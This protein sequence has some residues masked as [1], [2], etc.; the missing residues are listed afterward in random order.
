MCPETIFGTFLIHFWSIEGVVSRGRAPG[1]FLDHLGGCPVPLQ[2]S[3]P[4]RHRARPSFR[5][6]PLGHVVAAPHAKW[7]TVHLG[8]HLHQQPFGEPKL[9]N[10]TPS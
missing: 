7:S 8:S 6:L 9:G 5:V 10:P 3:G 2:C 1:T 4:R